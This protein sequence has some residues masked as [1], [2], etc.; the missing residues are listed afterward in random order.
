MDREAWC[1]VVHGVAESDTTEWLNWLT[2]VGAS[3]KES[4]YQCRRYRRCRFDAWFGKILWSRKWQPI[5]VFLPGKSY[6]QRSLVGC[7]FMGSQRAGHDW[8]LKKICTPKSKHSFWAICSPFPRVLSK[9]W[10]NGL[11]KMFISVEAEHN[12]GHITIKDLL[13]QNLLKTIRWEDAIFWT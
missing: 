11:K 10:P 2:E 12:Q 5:P 13:L 4:A 8:V 9:V 6:W 1:A 3:G 7:S